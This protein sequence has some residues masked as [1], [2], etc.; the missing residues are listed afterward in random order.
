MYYAPVEYF[1]PA[2]Y[3]QTSTGNKIS[4]AASITNPQQLEIPNGKVVIKDG[5]NIN[6]ENAKVSLLKYVFV[7]KNCTLNPCSLTN[8]SG[9]TKPVPLTIGAHTFIGPNSK[10]EAAVIGCGCWIG[11]N[12]VIGPR[13]VLKDYVLVEPNTIITADT[14]IPPFSCVSASHDVNDS[15]RADSTSSKMGRVGFIVDQ[16]PESAVLTAPGDGIARY[17]SFVPKQR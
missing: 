17:K 11:A 1:D 14:C 16:V 15:C 10:I 2:D 7:S 12:V 9:E 3:I 5:V 8:A 13:V 4:K 6:C